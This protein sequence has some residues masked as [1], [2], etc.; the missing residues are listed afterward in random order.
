MKRNFL[1]GLVVSVMFLLASQSIFAQVTVSGR[2][3]EASNGNGVYMVHIDA[4]P[5]SVHCG[6]WSGASALTNG[7]GY[8]FFESPHIYCSIIIIP[9]K[10]GRTFTPG[11]IYMNGGI[12]PY[13][14]NDFVAN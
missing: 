13:D 10:K 4:I 1:F 14:N 5:T 2:V 3:T 11:S 8:Y 6:S 12:D 9:S 7:F